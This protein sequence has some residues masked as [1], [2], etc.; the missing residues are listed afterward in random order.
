MLQSILHKVATSLRHLMKKFELFIVG[1][2]RGDKPPEGAVFLV[3]LHYR[4]AF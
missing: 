4:Q 2:A 3:R 1:V